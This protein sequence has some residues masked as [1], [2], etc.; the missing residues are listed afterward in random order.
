VRLTIN[1]VLQ[2]RI[3]ASALASMDSVRTQIHS[4]SFSAIAP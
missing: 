4:G 1:P 2:P 3:P